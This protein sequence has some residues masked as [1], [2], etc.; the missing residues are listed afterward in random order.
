[1]YWNR[2]MTF[3]K[4]EGEWLTLTWDVLKWA[5]KDPKVIKE[6]RLTLTWDVLKYFKHLALYRA[7]LRLTLTWDVLK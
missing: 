4:D 3:E 2:I 1:M 7:T 5:E 6:F